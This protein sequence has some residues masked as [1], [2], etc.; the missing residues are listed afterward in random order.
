MR[1]PRRSRIHRQLNVAHFYSAGKPLLH[2]ANCSCKGEKIGGAI[3]RLQILFLVG[4]PGR[5]NFHLLCWV[6]SEWLA[7]NRHV[8]L[9]LQSSF[10]AELQE[11]NILPEMFSNHCVHPQKRRNYFSSNLLKNQDS[12]P[13]YSAMQ[14]MVF[15]RMKRHTVTRQVLHEQNA[16]PHALEGGDELLE[17]SL[18]Y[19]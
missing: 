18:C 3:K 13:M 9:G 1:Q 17:P 5:A 15:F 19:C 10:Q 8:S 14:S 6:R 11:L 2:V 4:A 12:I 16:N 7:H